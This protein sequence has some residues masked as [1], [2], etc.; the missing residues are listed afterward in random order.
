M[1]KERLRNYRDLIKEREQIKQKIENIEAALYSP[2]GQKLTGMPTGGRQDN[3][4]REDLIEK[5]RTL[6][7]HYQAKEAALA[8]EQLSI[9]QAIDALSYRKRTLLRLYYIDRL[10]WEEVC[11]KMNYSWRQIHRIHSNA[12]KDLKKQEEPE[13]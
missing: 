6:L 9:E 4:R 10:T 7:E 5:R 3:D 8:A 1:T 13:A 12:L 11:I 2:H